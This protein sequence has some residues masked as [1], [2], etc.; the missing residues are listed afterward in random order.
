MVHQILSYNKKKQQAIS[1]V[2]AGVIEGDPNCSG[3][4]C[5]SIYDTKPVHFLTMAS[6]EIKWITKER[7]VYDTKKNTKVSMEFYRTNLQ[8]EYNYDMNKIDLG[9]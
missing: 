8:D 2:K 7:D 1:T 9:G 5:C 3:L 4:V 6:E